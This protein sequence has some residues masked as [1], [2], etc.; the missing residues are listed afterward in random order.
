[1]GIRLSEAFVSACVV[2]RYFPPSN[3]R[4]GGGAA[5]GETLATLAR[6]SES[7]R[8]EQ[9]EGATRNVDL[10]VAERVLEVGEIASKP[11]D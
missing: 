1:M 9:G 10:D 8:M 11:I 5:L 7:D 4:G 2:T 6:S 3:M